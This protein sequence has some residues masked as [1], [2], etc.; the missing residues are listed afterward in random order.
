MAEQNFV[1]YY[2]LGSK[3]FPFLWVFRSFFKVGL[4]ATANFTSLPSACIMIVSKL[5]GEC[6]IAAEIQLSKTKLLFLFALFIFS[7][8]SALPHIPLV[9][10]RT[11]KPFEIILLAHRATTSGSH[12]EP[13]HN[14]SEAY[15][16]GRT[17]VKHFALKK[18]EADCYS[19]LQRRFCLETH[20]NR[21]MKNI[22]EDFHNSAG[23]T[24]LLMM[25]CSLNWTRIICDYLST[26]FLSIHWLHKTLTSSLLLV[27]VP[28]S[29][30]W[31]SHLPH[32]LALQ[33]IHKKFCRS[34]IF[35]DEY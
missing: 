33:K 13:R 7:L 22:T 14:L 15:W 25:V 23:S 26:A 17:K 30:L 34:L 21:V 8:A 3:A 6:R 27:A 28:L 18:C 1:V 19:L 31:P 32:A 16:K 12:Q 20:I 2:G 10:F 29:T 24:F 4:G 5:P 9:H 11:N 35:K